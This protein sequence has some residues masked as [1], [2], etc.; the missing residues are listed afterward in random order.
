MFSKSAQCDFVRL[1]LFLKFLLGT[2]KQLG[3]AWSG[4]TSTHVH[5]PTQSLHKVLAGM[6]IPLGSWRGCSTN[7]HLIRDGLHN[8]VPLILSLTEAQ[9]STK[10]FYRP[11]LIIHF[12]FTTPREADSFQSYHPFVCLRSLGE[13]REK[14]PALGTE[15]GE[16]GGKGCRKEAEERGVKKRSGGHRDRLKKNVPKPQPW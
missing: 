10:S 5:L 8:G 3:I 9:Q 12:I 11:P 4:N 6:E 13:P 2:I 1:C 15:E 7:D 14:P 16:E